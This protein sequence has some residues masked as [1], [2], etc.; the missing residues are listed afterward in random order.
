MKYYYI[1]FWRGS[2]IYIVS[3]YYKTLSD[4]SKKVN[5]TIEFL[6]KNHRNE[7]LNILYGLAYGVISL[8]EKITIPKKSIG[9][10]INTE[11]L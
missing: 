7:Y 4:A 3:N 2:K 8:K 5:S 1:A 6:H 9:V 11:V 10:K